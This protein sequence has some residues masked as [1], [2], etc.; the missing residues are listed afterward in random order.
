ML[1]PEL[2]DD[3]A[4]VYDSVRDWSNTFRLG[5][6]PPGLPRRVVAAVFALRL[7][8]REVAANLD[9]F[10]K[11]RNMAE[12]VEETA[13]CLQEWACTRDADQEVLTALDAAGFLRGGEI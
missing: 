3:Y 13:D 12:F 9:L 1:T 6:D 2:I 7:L 5:E 10:D 11:G 8:H 4:E